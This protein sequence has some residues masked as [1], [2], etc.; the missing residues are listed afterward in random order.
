MPV[1]RS[2]PKAQRPSVRVRQAVRSARGAMTQRQL[3]AALR[4]DQSKVSRWERGI[5]EPTLDEIAAIEKATGRPRG[6]ILVACGSVGDVASVE[7][8]VAADAQLKDDW[9]AHV[10]DAYRAAVEMSSR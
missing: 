7:Q 1:D 2:T 9:R 10:L 8:A 4:V 6:W 3:A 5:M